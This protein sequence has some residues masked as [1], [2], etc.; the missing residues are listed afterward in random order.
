MRRFRKAGKGS[1]REMDTDGERAN[2]R[3][4]IQNR[5]EGPA[6][7]KASFFTFA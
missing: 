6:A 1:S 7:A 5:D 2:Q 4:R 3:I